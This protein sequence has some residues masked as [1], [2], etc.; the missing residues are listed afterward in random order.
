MTRSIKEFLRRDLVVNNL[1]AKSAE[2]VFKKMSPILLEAGF[3]E[4]SFFNGLVNRESKF[5]TGLLLGK[6]NVA[7]P[8]T[9]A[10]HVKKP[11][12]AIAT[13]KNPVKFNSMDGNGSVDVN[14][15][16][17]MA[18][19]EPHSQIAML[20]QLMFLIQNESILENMLQAKNSDEVYDIV[21]SF[22]CN[23]E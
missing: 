4:D 3:V 1:E 16:F 15:V 21:S 9:D 18:L 14:I 17:T 12:I 7:I 6:Y 8:H 20:Q 2:D 22:N 19:N 10:I 5:P 11:A 23:C 13:L